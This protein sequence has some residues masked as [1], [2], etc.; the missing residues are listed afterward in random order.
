MISGAI[1]VIWLSSPALA[2]RVLLVFQ[3]Q[4]QRGRNEQE[5][6]RKSRHV[7]RVAGIIGDERESVGERRAAD[8]RQQPLSDAVDVRERRRALQRLGF[9]LELGRELPA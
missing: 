4:N 7:V 6:A 8:L 9:A 3:S 5:A 2:W 1:E